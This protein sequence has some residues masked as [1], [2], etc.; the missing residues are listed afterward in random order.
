MRWFGDFIFVVAR[1]VW[2]EAMLIDKSLAIRAHGRE[3]VLGEMAVAGVQ[4]T[5][6]GW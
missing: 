2:L 3:H 1:P 5:F 4:V 6:D